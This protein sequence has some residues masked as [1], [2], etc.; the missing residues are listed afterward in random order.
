MERQAAEAQPAN[1]SPRP[2]RHGL[3][4]RWL[5]AIALGALAIAALSAGPLGFAA[6]IVAAAAVLAWEWARLCGTSIRR[7]PGFWVAIATIGASAV[8]G[9]LALHREAL[10]LLI[11]A[12]TICAFTARREAGIDRAW[13]VGG[14]LY[15]GAACVAIIW[16]RRHAGVEMV[17]SVMLAV[18]ATDVAAF[19]V[20]R[21]V[22]G[23]RLAPRISPNKT[24]SGL[25]GG[26]TAS[27]ALGAILGKLELTALSVAG[28]AIAAAI[29]AVVAQA[30]DLAE[31]A[32][33]R[34]FGVKDSSSLIPGH[35]GLLDRVDGLLA[36]ALAVAATIVATGW[37][38]T[39]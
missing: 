13:L 2:A 21:A 32:A 16:L 27:A 14:A 6:L 28:S 3:A 35:G 19:F 31:S 10:L 26:M 30:G 33:K 23:P 15:L 12:S 34:Q 38:P 20:G 11:A 7:E 22:G 36:A 1:E 37:T 5:S 39:R 4:A 8:A 29:L 24:W 25:I 9:A 17:L 18:V